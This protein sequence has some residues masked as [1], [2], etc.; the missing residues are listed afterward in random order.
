MNIKVRFVLLLIPFV[1][2]SLNQLGSSRL[3]GAHHYRQ[4]HDCLMARTF[5]TSETNILRP[6]IDGVTFKRE[7]YLNDFPLYPYMLGMLWRVFGEHL[8]LGRLLSLAFSI[9]ALWYFHR[10]LLHF[11]QDRFLADLA[12]LLCSLTPVMTYFGHTIQRQ[13][14]FMML[15]LGGTFHMARY[16]SE[17]RVATWLAGTAML[18]VAVLLNPYAVYMAIPLGWLAFQ[19]R[20]WHVLKEWPLYITALAVVA[21]AAAWYSHTLMVGRTLPTAEMMGIS[22]QVAHRDFFGADHFAMW[23]NSGNWTRLI[24]SLARYAVPSFPALAL[25]LYGLWQGKRQQGLSFF[26]VWFGAVAVYHLVDFYPAAVTIHQ[27]YFLNTVPVASVFLAHGLLCLVRRLC[28]IQWADAPDPVPPERA[29]ILHVARGRRAMVIACCLA[30]TV[31]AFAH[32]AFVY[33]HVLTSKNWHEQY[34]DIPDIIQNHV[35]LGEKVTI[36]AES[37]DPLIS[38]VLAPSITHRL[39]KYSPERLDLLLQSGSPTQHGP[40]L[41]LYDSPQFPL[42]KVIDALRRSGVTGAPAVN[43]SCFMLFRPTPPSASKGDP[44]P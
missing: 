4:A 13:A 37:D 8:V 6:A 36:I 7:L 26:A 10:L 17:R 38:F 31:V 43:R 32:S 24:R 29:L 33:N 41:L 40:I 5:A 21:P 11:V 2:L 44:A 23:A 27:Y 16:L 1:V 20:Q 22:A 18:A 9:L 30:L 28:R 34:Y 42:E 35:L 39:I 12:L 19:H 14:L 3:L 25:C 15:L